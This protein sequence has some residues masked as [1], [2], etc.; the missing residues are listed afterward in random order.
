MPRLRQ[1]WFGNMRTGRVA[2]GWE[3]GWTGEDGRLQT[4]PEGAGVF[5]EHIP[6]MSVDSGR[7][8][9]SRN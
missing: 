2:V 8:F 1:K 3:R 4:S 7:F 5:W 6:S 9:V